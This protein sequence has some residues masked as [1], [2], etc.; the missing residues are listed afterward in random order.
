MSRRLSRSAVSCSGRRA[1]RSVE[2][3]LQQRCCSRCRRLQAFRGAFRR[4]VRSPH[5]PEPKERVALHET[6]PVHA[7]RKLECLDLLT[8]RLVLSLD[9]LQGLGPRLRGDS[10][11]QPVTG[12]RPLERVIGRLESLADLLR[13]DRS[14]PDRLR[15][16]G[17]LPGPVSATCRSVSSWDKFFRSSFA[18]AID[19]CDARG[20]CG[21]NRDGRNSPRF[22][23]Y[24]K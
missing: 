4:R 16:P 12:P 6:V 22:R 11:S 5:R 2:L 18:P 7:R 24:R 21:S 19:C 3:C 13:F 1:F 20:C 15:L 23:E 14:R 9:L 10:D 17:P 8:C